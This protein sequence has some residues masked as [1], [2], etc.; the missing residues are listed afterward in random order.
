MGNTV[1]A[2]E[3]YAA[4]PEDIKAI[5]LPSHSFTDRKISEFNHYAKLTGLN[6][7]VL[8]VKD[9]HCWIRWQSKNK[10]AAKWVPSPQTD[11]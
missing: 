7:V 1:I 10:L 3:T 6:A 5:Y 8:H 4:K 11:W 2:S 9:P